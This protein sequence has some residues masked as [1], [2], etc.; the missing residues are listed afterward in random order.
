MSVRPNISYSELL[1]DCLIKF[2]C[3]GLHQLSEEFDVHSVLY[4]PCF[5]TII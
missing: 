3:G 2:E 4:K 5:H 1:E